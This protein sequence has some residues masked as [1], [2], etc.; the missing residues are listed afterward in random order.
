MNA[1][2]FF[3]ILIPTFSVPLISNLYF[4][5]NGSWSYKQILS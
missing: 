2:E 3:S 5:S 1:V 4:D